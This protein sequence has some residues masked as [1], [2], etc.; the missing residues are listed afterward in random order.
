MLNVDPFVKPVDSPYDPAFL[1]V[2]FIL[3]C[4]AMLC[5]PGRKKHKALAFG[6]LA[7]LLSPLTAYA[8]IAGSGRGCGWSPRGAASAER[9]RDRAATAFRARPIP[10]F[11]DPIELR[12]PSRIYDAA[13]D[14]PE[15][16]RRYEKRIKAAYPIHRNFDRLYRCPPIK[17][18]PPRCLLRGGY[19]TLEKGDEPAICRDR[20]R[21]T[22][23]CSSS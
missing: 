10:P 11:K 2:C 8:F 21:L 19:H 17:F 6:L 22:T 3:A 23:R 13:Q 4:L 16:R 1:A 15:P 5:L 7:L 9:L 12:E 20:N 14:S 18:Q